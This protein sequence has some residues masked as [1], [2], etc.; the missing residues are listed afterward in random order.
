MIRLGKAEAP[1]FHAKT[2]IIRSEELGPNRFSKLKELEEQAKRKKFKTLQNTIA[3]MRSEDP[4]L[5]SAQLNTLLQDVLNRSREN[6]DFY[7]GVR[8]IVKVSQIKTDRGDVLSEMQK[9]RLIDAYHFLFNERLSSLF[10][11]CH[12]ALWS[13]FERTNDEQNLLRLFRHSSLI[14]RLRDLDGREQNYAKRLAQVVRPTGRIAMGLPR[15]TA[16]F[17]TRTAA[18]LLSFTKKQDNASKGESGA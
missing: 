10:D 11:S 1:A 4:A 14:W 13:E 3:L 18:L 8:A 2:I 17:L 12:G 6:K 5:D 15:E 7:N 16:Y 9:L